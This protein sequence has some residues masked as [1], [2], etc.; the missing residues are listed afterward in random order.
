M[1]GGPNATTP[2]PEG[3][4][5]LP[6]DSPPTIFTRFKD[7]GGFTPAEVVALLAS[8][9]IGCADHVDPGLNAAPFDS[10]PFA[11]DTKFYL[12]VLPKGVELPGFSNN[13][14]E[15]SSPLLTGETPNAGELTPSI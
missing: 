1:V 12:K 5:P 9:S 2:P 4:I 8:H 6:S 10:T 7:G 14:G 3:L 11:F 13:S 15:V